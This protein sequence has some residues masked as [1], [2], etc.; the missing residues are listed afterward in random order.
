LR[1]SLIVAVLAAPLV[2]VLLTG[3]AEAQEGTLRMIGQGGELCSLWTAL[4]E[5]KLEVAASGVE[6][7]V[8]GFLSGVGYGSVGYDPQ[9]NP[10]RG[11]ED[12]GAV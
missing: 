2:T 10:L 7:W 9:L 6:Q 3:S 1:K 5:N 4:R 8:L 11:V 12:A